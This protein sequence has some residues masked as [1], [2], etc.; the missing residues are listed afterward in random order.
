M[1][2]P[3][4]E[5]N[6]NETTPFNW[7]GQK[8]RAA[9]LLA[10][11]GLP[12]A[13]IAARLKVTDRTLRLWKAHPEFAA[14]VKQVVAELGERSLRFAVGRRHRRV[15]ALDR[16]WR[17]MKRVMA[18]RAAA[19]EMA[20]VPGGTTGLLVR[21]VKSM[22]AGENAREVEEFEVDTG[23]LKELRELEKQAAQELGQWA[24]KRELSG[25]NGQPVAFVEVRLTDGRAADRNG[26]SGGEARPGLQLP[27]GPEPGVGE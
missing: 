7:T 1:N 15:K 14:R 13:R 20:T 24:E 22:G 23:L 26:D 8:Q 21:K 27:P 11:D 16:R 6:G 17:K 3:E 10:E 4:P 18:Q 9:A 12:D 25:P 2:G 5:K 19:P